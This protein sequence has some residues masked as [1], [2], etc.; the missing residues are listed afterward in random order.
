[1]KYAAKPVI[2]D[3]FRIVSVG[4]RDSAGNL[5]VTLDDGREMRADAAMLARMQP[6]VGDY[7]VIQEDG[8]MYLNPAAVFERK[9]GPIPSNLK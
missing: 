8:Y 2:V 6:L 5:D 4:Q 1:M 7:W 9:Y 3:A